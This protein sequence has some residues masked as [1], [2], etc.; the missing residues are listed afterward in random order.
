MRSA[1][2][3]CSKAIDKRPASGIERA[4]VGDGSGLNAGAH[5]FS[6]MQR[7]SLG[8]DQRNAESPNLREYLRGLIPNRR[9]RTCRSDAQ[10]LNRSSSLAE[11]GKDHS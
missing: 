5:P 3:S 1:G 9:V 11:L 4:T 6:P 7:P 2:L 10:M 8:P